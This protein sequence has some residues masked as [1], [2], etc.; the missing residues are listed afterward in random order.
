MHTEAVIHDGSDE[1]LAVSLDLSEAK[2]DAAQRC[3]TFGNKGV[4][5]LIFTE[6]SPGFCSEFVSHSFELS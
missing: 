5:L 2:S 3:H 1:R 6:S 4:N